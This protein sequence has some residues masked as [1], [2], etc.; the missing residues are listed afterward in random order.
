MSPNGHSPTL[1]DAAVLPAARPFGWSLAAQRAALV[2]AL[3]VGDT[4]ALVAAFGLSY[5]IRFDLKLTLAPGVV[6]S[7]EFY[8]SLSSVLVPLW[9]ALFAA[10][11]LY[12]PQAKLGGALE[13]SRAFNACTAATLLV[14]I[15]TFVAPDL[16][17]SR[18][19]LLS[20]WLLSFLLVAGNRFVARRGVYALRRRGFLLTPA[21][22][23]GLNE[24]AASLA[25]FLGESQY[26]GVRPLG[27]VAPAGADRH[28]A[29]PLPI[30]G[31]LDEVADVVRRHDAA[32]VVVAITAVTREELLRLC[33]DLDHL[34]VHLRLSSGLYE[35]L[36]TRVTVQTQGNVPLLCVQKNRLSRGEAVAKTLLEWPLAVGGLLVLAPVLLAIAAL[37]RLDSP[38]PIFHRRRVLGAGRRE[39]DALK[40]RTMFVN[41]DELLE[42]DRQAADELRDRHKLRHDPRVTRLGHWLRR[43]SLDELPQLFNVVA[44]QM[45]LVGPRMISPEEAVKYGRSRMNLLTVK[46][47]I[48]GLWQVSGRS[49]LSYDERVRIDMFYVRNYSVWLD[50]QIL[51]VQTLPA[52]LKGRGA[53]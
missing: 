47:G 28:P 23:V 43:F 38:G 31:T 50:L 48:T 30:L 29:A 27:M 6:P 39:F 41:G 34:P 19:W 26:S 42:A 46:P 11:R 35:L 8:P 16:D 18:L 2:V 51:F 5:W 22:I 14:V 32:D 33:E 52:V 17:V 3:A 36:T 21:V 12:D 49:E 15:G 40:F 10:F 7:P 53:Y 45:A 25:R 20:V 13:S 37:V 1:T 24:E 9:L 44:G 4:A